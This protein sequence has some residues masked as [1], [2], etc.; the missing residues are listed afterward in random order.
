MNKDGFVIYKSF[1]DPIKSLS[2]KQLGRLFRALFDYQIE[3]STQVDADIQ[4]AFAFFK[5]QMEIDERKYHKIVERNKQNGSKGGRPP[6]EENPNNP[7]NPVGFL[8]PKKADKE[9]DKEKDL[10]KKNTKK[11]DFDLSFVDIVFLPIVR[12]FIEYRKE[13]KKPFKT[14]TGIKQFYKE[15]VTL[16]GNNYQKAQKLVDHAKGKEWLR[17]YEIKNESNKRNF[18]R[19][20]HSGE[21]L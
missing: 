17:V 13:L 5:N 6:K 19:K 21:H 14:D 15:L 2:D 3:G 1:Y 12:D 16:S 18:E 11:K 10:I 7:N 8:E 9:K 20:N 4:M